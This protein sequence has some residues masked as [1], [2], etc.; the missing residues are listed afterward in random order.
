MLERQLRDAVQEIVLLQ[1]EVKHLRAGGAGNFS[2]KAREALRLQGW[3]S[4]KEWV[5]W[6]YS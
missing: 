4:A 6:R 5:E 3:R 2:E 1:L